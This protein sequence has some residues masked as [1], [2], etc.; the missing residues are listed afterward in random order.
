MQRT[1]LAVDIEF[2][3]N[4]FSNLIQTQGKARQSK[5]LCYVGEKVSRGFEKYR[6]CIHTTGKKLVGMHI[7]SDKTGGTPIQLIVMNHYVNTFFSVAY[8]V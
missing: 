8:D 5:T 1:L 2:K 4:Q 3:N 7:S 6:I